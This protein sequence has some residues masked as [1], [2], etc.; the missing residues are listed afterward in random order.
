MDY[1]IQRERDRVKIL[2]VASCYRN[3]PL[4][5]NGLNLYQNTDPEN[6]CSA[7]QKIYISVVQPECFTKFFIT[8][9]TS[10]GMNVIKSTFI[11]IG[12]S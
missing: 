7:V 8:S 3:G 11:L 1:P 6:E 10:Q 5:S 4:G 12:R 9:K 2:L